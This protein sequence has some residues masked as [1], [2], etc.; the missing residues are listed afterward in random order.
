M[1]QE[2][3][4]DIRKNRASLDHLNLTVNNFNE[5]AH[6]YNEIFGFEI[7][8][9]GKM[10]DG[11]PWGVLKSSDSMLCIYEGIRKPSP[12]KDDYYDQYH[13]IYH[14]GLRLHDKA[15]WENKIKEKH[16]KVFYDGAIQYPH[17]NSW[18]IQDPSGHEIEVVIW[19]RDQVK[20]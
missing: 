7:V 2:T 16:L 20:F 18:Y 9:S 3:P 10:P 5:S 15:Q 13:R 19:N 11:R 1:S 8:E 12:D 6:W 14:F 17:S 4:T